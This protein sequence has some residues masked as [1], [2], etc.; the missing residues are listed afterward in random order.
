MQSAAKSAQKSTKTRQISRRIRHAQL[1]K[2]SDA[3]L[4]GLD[5]NERGP[6]AGL[7][8]AVAD[9]LRA[10]L[11]GNCSGK[12]THFEAF[13]RCFCVFL[14]CFGCFLRLFEVI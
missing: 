6:L 1:H 4:D 5:A 7:V 10:C 11:G 3:A 8:G 2:P 14:R 13:L 12:L 9:D